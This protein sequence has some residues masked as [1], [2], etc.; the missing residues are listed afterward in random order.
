MNIGLD[1]SVVL[2]LLVGEPEPQFLAA[3]KLVE[4]IRRAGN[5]AVVDDLV[6]AETYFAAQYHYGVSKESILTALAK[7]L[8]A[9][10]ILFTGQSATILTLPA[11][12][13]AK[14]GFVDR[15]IHASYTQA[16]GRMATF[17]KSAGKLAN[18]VVLK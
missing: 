8:A 6:V 12:H 4:E 9:G 10:E 5:R 1:T 3:A 16:G 7:M 2:R 14:P 11:L 17:E 18:V 15:M 13:S